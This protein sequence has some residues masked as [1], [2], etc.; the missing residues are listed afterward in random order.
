MRYGWRLGP[1]TGAGAG[2]A[3][4]WGLV[5]LVVGLVGLLIPAVLVV[6]AVALAGWAFRGLSS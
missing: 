2:P 5:A 4:A 3:M 6:V 1:G